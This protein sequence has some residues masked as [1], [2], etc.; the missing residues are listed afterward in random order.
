[1]ATFGVARALPR[2]R[3]GVAAPPVGQT[4]FSPLKA[5]PLSAMPRRPY[6][7]GDPSLMGGAAL[8][9]PGLGGL[10]GGDKLG[11]P[12]PVAPT[13]P[14]AS[15]T[16]TAQI[17]PRLEALG[18]RYGDWMTQYEKGTGYAAEVAGQK[19]R[20]IRE[21]GRRALAEETSL[22][23]RDVGSAL[24]GY[25]SETARQ[26]AEAA[27]ETGLRRE[28][29]LGEAIRGG[30]PLAE[31]PGAAAREEKRVGISAK[32]LDIREREAQARL[33]QQQMDNFFRMLQLMSSSI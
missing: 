32:E 30:L 23:G 22:T 13:T 21:G 12:G 4:P 18:K 27:T 10:F 9:I 14:A 28:E 17:D 2:P 8:K 11:A 20:D 15:T 16:I 33:A 31:A 24:S 1:M 6:V 25:E 3:R 7:G 19:A 26:A 5:Q 29:K